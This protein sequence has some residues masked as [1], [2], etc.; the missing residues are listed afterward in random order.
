MTSIT[1]AQFIDIAGK[2]FDEAVGVS[3]VPEPQP[4]SYTFKVPPKCSSRMRQF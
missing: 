1:K 2:L 4:A 3:P